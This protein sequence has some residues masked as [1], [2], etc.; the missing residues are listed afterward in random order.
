MNQS[1]LPQT[2]IAIATIDDSG[3]KFQ[4][5]G[6]K[7][8][9]F[10]AA[11]LTKTVF[12]Y[13]TH[14]LID[15]GKLLLDEPLYNYICGSPVIDGLDIFALS[16]AKDITARHVLTHSSGLP[17]WNDGKITELLFNSGEK[18]AYSGLGFCLLQ[19]A[20]EKILNTDICQ[21]FDEYVFSPFGMANSSLV[22]NYKIGKDFVLG[23]N[24]KGI[25]E[26]TNVF[27]TPCVAY[28]L[29]TTAEDFAAF[30][31]GAMAEDYFDKV[32]TDLRVLTTNTSMGLGMLVLCGKYAFQWGDNNSFKSMLTVDVAS[33]KAVIIFTNFYDGLTYCR[34]YM[35]TAIPNV[36]NAICEYLDYAY[37][38]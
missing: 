23:I 37:A 7:A 11:S 18:F 22:I 38:D 8:A 29:Y 25:A 28:S 2:V 13:I 14:K 30:V 5:I 19:N 35:K 3:A 1:N 9:V 34:E 20:V 33:K 16:G 36:Q 15:N 26:R 31:S 10:S 6:K 27:D 12:A 4:H 24:D 17:N 32:F 21:I